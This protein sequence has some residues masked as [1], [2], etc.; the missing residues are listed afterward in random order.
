LAQLILAQTHG[1]EMV[2]NQ[3]D[4]PL[5]RVQHALGLAERMVAEGR[6]EAARENLELAQVQLG[7]YR[8]LLGQEA[9]QVVKQLEDDITTLMSKTEEK[10]A[11]EKIRGFW[12]RAVKMFREESGQAHT[13][14]AVPTVQTN[15][16]A[17]KK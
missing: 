10:G 14:D 12:E 13:V 17:T 15:Q 11:A 7:T 9:G 16:P 2:V 3:A 4:S 6:Y 5:V 1:I 8:A